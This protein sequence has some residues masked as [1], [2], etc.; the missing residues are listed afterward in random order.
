M[1]DKIT[2]IY[3]KYIM[4]EAWYSIS[5]KKEPSEGSILAEACAE[6]GSPWYSGHFPGDPILPGIAILS[7]VTDA[8]THHESGKGKK[9]RITSI[10][11]VRF[12]LPV[13]PDELLHISTSSSH[14][15]GKLAYHFDVDVRGKTAC[16]GIIMAELLPE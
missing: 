9:I 8:I 6:A 12:R 11:R 7:M 3:G 1:I 5:Y 2:Y 13:R 15:D 16:T 10:K 14:Q 4:D